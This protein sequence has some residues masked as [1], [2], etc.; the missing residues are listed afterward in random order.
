MLLLRKQR[1]SERSSERSLAKRARRKIPRT[2]PNSDAR[3]KLMKVSVWH[4]WTSTP[5]LQ[6]CFMF[7]LS[8]N[9]NNT[10]TH[11]IM[12]YN[13]S[14]LLAV[15]F[16]FFA[17]NANATTHEVSTL[18]LNDAAVQMDLTDNLADGSITANLLVQLPDGSTQRKSQKYRNMTQAV[19]DCTRFLTEL[20]YGSRL[21]RAEF[22]N[23]RGEVVF[24][25]AG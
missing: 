2:S 17:F 18:D 6:A 7:A 14:S 22:T 21:L 23:A 24:Q 4:E 5:G 13:V 19:N 3:H 12:K 8:T 1:D 16:A 10:K 15:A 11:T 9:N 20:P 25:F